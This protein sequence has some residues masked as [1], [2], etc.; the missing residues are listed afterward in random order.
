MNAKYTK[1]KLNTHFERRIEKREN[2]KYPVEMR[3][4]L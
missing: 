2:N 1:K 4:I 3:K